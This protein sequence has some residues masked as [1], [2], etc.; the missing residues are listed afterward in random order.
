MK[1]IDAGNTFGSHF[2][3]VTPARYHHWG[4]ARS[5]A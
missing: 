3:G 5:R 4:L 1:P 2:R